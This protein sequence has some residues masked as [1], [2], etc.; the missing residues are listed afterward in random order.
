MTSATRPRTPR[1][2][3]QQLGAQ[4]RSVLA[5]LPLFLTA[6]L[7]RRWHLRW[8]AT[9]DEVDAALP[10]DELFPQAQFRCTRAITIQ[11]PPALV[12]PWLVQVGCLRAGFYSNDLLDNLGHPS[13]RDIVPEL[14]HV[15]VGQWIPMSPTGPSDATALRVEAFD[16]NH[17]LLWRKPDSTWVWRLTDTGHGTTRLLTR[18]HATYRWNRPLTALLGVALMEFGDFPMM[19]R[20]LRG[21]KDRAEALAQDP[22]N[23]VV[24]GVNGVAPGVGTPVGPAPTSAA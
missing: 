12:W 18:V 14:Q 24:D 15:E 5:D 9:A 16:V 19:R 21:I 7:F 20:M 1:P 13:A 8:G 3:P 17:W 2:T 22:H 10:G 23:H 4:V 11:A 6:P